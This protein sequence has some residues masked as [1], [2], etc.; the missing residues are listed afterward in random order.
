VAGT[1]WEHQAGCS[2]ATTAK[3]PFSKIAR[4]RSEQPHGPVSVRLRVV[5]LAQRERALDQ[6]GLRPNIAPL[7][8][9]SLPWP[10]ACVGEDA[11]QRG[12]TR[13]GKAP[14]PFDDNRRKRPNLLASR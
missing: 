13:A 10:K 5:L 14:H 4:E 3:A 11:Q 12:V 9:E 8:C 6:D 1:R 7:Q 2:G